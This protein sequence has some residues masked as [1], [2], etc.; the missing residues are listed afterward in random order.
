MNSKLI[1]QILYEIPE[2]TEE[3]DFLFSAFDHS[4]AQRDGIV[5]MTAG[6]LPELDAAKTKILEWENKFQSYLKDQEIRLK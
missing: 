4:V 1:N 2:F 3:L 6:S 5:E